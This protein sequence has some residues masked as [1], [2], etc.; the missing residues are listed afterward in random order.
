MFKVILVMAISAIVIAG[1]KDKPGIGEPGYDLMNSKCGKCHFT[2]VKKAHSTKEE[3]DKTVTRMMGK[4]AT[5]NDT[6]KAT[7]IDFLVKYYHP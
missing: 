6:E 2:G 3:W 5:L 4:G 1:C 7:L